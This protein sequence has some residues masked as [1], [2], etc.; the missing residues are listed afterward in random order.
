MTRWQLFPPAMFLVLL[1]SVWA[2]SRAMDLLAP[3]RQQQG[4]RGKFRPYACGEDV[5]DPRAPPD[6]SQF[7]HFAFFFTILHVVALV[8]ATVPRGSP[9][10]AALAVGLLVSAV[11]ALLML[12]RR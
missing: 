12:F 9:G 4:P 8:V 2:Q 11:V 7:F 5:D 6:Y 1:A 10:A 3:P